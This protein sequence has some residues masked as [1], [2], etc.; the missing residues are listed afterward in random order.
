MPDKFIRLTPSQRSRYNRLIR[1]LCANYDDGNCI[2]LDDGETCV[3]PQTISYSLLCKYFRMAVLPADNKLSADIYR[4]HT[5]SC[6]V[7]GQ[8]FVPASN[9]QKYCKSCAVKIHRKQ[10][11]EYAR[12]RQ[13]GTCKR[14]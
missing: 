8:A 5:I 13:L 14:L 12:R 1:R 4:V 3:C 10:K 9:R 7:C 11:A 2:L 6:T